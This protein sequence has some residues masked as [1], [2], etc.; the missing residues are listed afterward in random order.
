MNYHL[1]IIAAHN[2]AH[3]SRIEVGIDRSKVRS[4][5]VREGRVG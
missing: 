2:G 4:V 5:K 1:Q 3:G